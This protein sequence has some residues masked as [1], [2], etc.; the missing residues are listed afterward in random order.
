MHP[1]SGILNFNFDGSFQKD[2]GQGG[3]VIWDSTG[4]ILLQFSGAVEC[5]D[6]NEADIYDMLNG[7]MVKLNALGISWIG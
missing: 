6:S 4:Q 5:L 3:G 1:P 2:S 7:D